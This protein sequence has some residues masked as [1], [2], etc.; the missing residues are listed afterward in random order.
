M[1]VLISRD[2]SVLLVIDIQE[3]LLPD[4]PGGEALLLRVSLLLEAAKVTG[5]PVLLTEHAPQGLGPTVGPIRAEL[6]PGT[7]PIIKTTFSCVYEPNFLIRLK[8]TDRRQVVIAG[9][10]THVCVTQTALEL[11]RGGWSVFLAA[12]ATGSP[13]PADRDVALERLRQAGIVVTTAESVVF[14]WMVRSG[15]PEF[16]A[17]QHRLK[18]LL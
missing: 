15:T 7:E 5:V 18:A 17:V 8:A 12:D 16:K 14:E 4:I 3:K 6:L 1:P 2:E 11:V 10:W 13:R 9:I